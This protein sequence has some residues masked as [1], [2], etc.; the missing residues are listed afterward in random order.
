MPRLCCL[1]AQSLSRSSGEAVNCT[2][3]E[4]IYHRT[5]ASVDNTTLP[6]ALNQFICHECRINETVLGADS[7]AN[8]VLAQLEDL[9]KEISSIKTLQD[10][11][12][13]AIKNF[14]NKLNVVTS[15]AQQVSS[16]SS[17]INNVSKAVSELH[18]K[19][20]KLDYF[21]KSKQL[22]ITGYPQSKNENLIGIVGKIATVVGVELPSSVLDKCFRFRPKNGRVQPI[23]VIFSSS[24]WRD[25]LLKAY[26]SR[27]SALKGADVGVVCDGSI[28]LGEHLSSDQQNLLTQTKEDLKQPGLAEFVWFQNNKVLVRPRQG[29]KISVVTSVTD[30]LRLKNTIMSSK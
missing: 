15:L 20:N 28:S 12:S 18:N 24:V 29:A 1:C 3:C 27:K 30:I 14:E 7:T 26:R 6:S 25:K 22:V 19:V 8:S 13:S 23:L 21:E 2:T 17:K 11:S 4:N 9:R 16:N 10:Q 5:C